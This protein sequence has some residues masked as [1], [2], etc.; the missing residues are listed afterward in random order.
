M[1]KIIVGLVMV[2][3]LWVGQAFAGT[4]ALTTVGTDTFTTAYH[5]MSRSWAHLTATNPTGAYLD[6]RRFTYLEVQ[7]VGTWDG[8]P[9]TLTLQGS[10]DASGGTY[11]TLTGLPAGV[12]TAVSYSANPT[13]LIPIWEI[14]NYVKP[15]LAGA[16]T[17]A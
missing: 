8:T 12:P 3:A 1:K 11:F 2:L 15:V 14:P 10:D 9:G 4:V 13:V 7:I 17:G 6:T 16:H 5:T